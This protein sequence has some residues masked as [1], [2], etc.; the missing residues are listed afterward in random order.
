MS[1][2][3][4]A[5]YQ[6]HSISLPSGVSNDQV[7]AVSGSSYYYPRDVAAGEEW[8]RLTF[9]LTS[10]DDGNTNEYFPLPFQWGWKK[11]GVAFTTGNWYLST[12]GRMHFTP[13]AEQSG[14]NGPI[15]PPN[16]GGISPDSGSVCICAHAGDLW[17]NESLMNVSWTTLL[18]TASFN[19]PPPNGWQELTIDQLAAYNIATDN[20]NGYMRFR[21]TTSDSNFNLRLET[22]GWKDSSGVY[23]QQPTYGNSNLNSYTVSQPNLTGVGSAFSFPLKA[24]NQN[25]ENGILTNIPYNVGNKVCVTYIGSEPPFNAS[26]NQGHSVF[27]YEKNW[28]D[29]GVQHYIYK[30]VVYCG[31]YGST[32]YDY[33]YRIT[34][35]KAGASQKFSISLA[36]DNSHRYPSQI[37]SG[38]YPHIITD[39]STLADSIGFTE[40]IWYSEDNGFTWNRYTAAPYATVTFMGSPLSVTPGSN[41]RKISDYNY[42][43]NP[44]NANAT[45]YNQSA[46]NTVTLSKYYGTHWAPGLGIATAL[47]EM[48]QMGPWQP[49]KQRVHDLFANA[50]F[51]PVKG[52]GSIYYKDVNADGNFNQTDV[53]EAQGYIT[54]SGWSDID[55][56]NQVSA[57]KDIL[58]NDAR[59]DWANTDSDSI[60]RQYVEAG[61]LIPNSN[62]Y[63]TTWDNQWILPG[64]KA[65][66]VTKNNLN[67][68]MFAGLGPI[69]KNT[70]RP[71]TTTYINK[72]GGAWYWWWND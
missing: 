43:F 47:Q 46:Q 63:S 17:L 41:N 23:N 12:N 67:T 22:I 32:T 42:I 25:S 44:I 48:L 30:I 7:P 14:P 53:T 68:S 4:V 2:E 18:G 21:Y 59:N 56:P 57:L 27:K 16:A 52:S 70:I 69:A 55:T 72:H 54:G 31:R 58:V 29:G 38:P 49:L 51:T 71:V 62:R 20:V 1:F 40:K 37:K 45:M 5:N 33:S 8:T 15:A 39:D 11:A 6:Q 64:V 3:I 24:Y 10:S 26:G 50:A 19:T 36:S 35:Y 28:L 60:M 65:V 34:L 61:Y 9:T 66:P 13:P